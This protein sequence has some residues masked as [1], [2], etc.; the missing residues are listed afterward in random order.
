M[1]NAEDSKRK[2]DMSENMKLWDAV[3][4]PPVS[5]LKTIGGGRLKGLT[6]VNPQ[7]RLKAMTEQFGPI[8]IGWKYD[9]ERLWVEAGP[10]GQVAAFATIS[11]RIRSPMVPD[12][13]WSEQIIGVGGSQMVQLESS[14]LRVNDECYKMAV[15]DAL[16]VAMKQLGVAAD[17]Y[18]G[19]WDGSKYRYAPAEPPKPTK[20][21][22]WGD[23]I[24]NTKTEAELRSLHKSMPQDQR[25]AWATE[26]AAKRKVLGF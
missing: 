22:G 16:S 14:G 7:W 6:D 13:A 11:L 9:I 24:T 25:E 1:S 2:P 3:C 21:D 17:I 8:G 26:I 19:L 10:D 23:R 4:R 15:T 12:G 20:A 5:V 18:A